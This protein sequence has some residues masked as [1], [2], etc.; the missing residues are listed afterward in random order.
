MKRLNGL[1]VF[2]FIVFVLSIISWSFS[3]SAA[4]HPGATAALAA[5]KLGIYR[6]PLGF[7]I[8]AGESGWKQS[9]APSDNRYI[10]TIYAAPKK[11]NQKGDSNDGAMLT[12]RVD[13]L[14]KSTTLERYVHKW[15]REYPK[16]GF[17]VIGSQSFVQKK[18]KGFVLDLINRDTGKQ[19]RQVVFLK[20]QKAVIMT[21]RDQSEMFKTTLQNCNQIIRTFEWVN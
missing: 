21:C 15:T 5:P 6:S 12:V 16:F 3:A 13:R 1:T 7:Q 2:E 14:A 17:D 9:A 19:L 10:A 11:N 4:P 8:S 18:D 20:N